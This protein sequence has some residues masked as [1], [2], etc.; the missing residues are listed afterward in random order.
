[1]HF[2]TRANSMKRADGNAFGENKPIQW[3]PSRPSSAPPPVVANEPVVA[4]EPGVA[5]E[6]FV[7]NDGDL[8]SGQAGDIETSVLAVLAS[9]LKDCSRSPE[10]HSPTPTATSAPRAC[11]TRHAG[12][13][14]ARRRRRGQ[15][16][17]GARGDP[18]GGSACRNRRDEAGGGVGGERR[19]RGGQ[20]STSKVSESGWERARKMNLATGLCVPSDPARECLV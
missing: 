4:D 15:A 13:A 17:Q 11:A 16:E 19:P 12:G 9:Q 7:S 1:M 5:D 6:L 18:S 8:S 2:T 10:I 14:R 20:I 3:W